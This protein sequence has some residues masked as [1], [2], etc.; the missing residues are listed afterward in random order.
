MLEYAGGG[1]RVAVEWLLDNADVAD[2]AVDIFPAVATL[3][4]DDC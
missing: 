1:V 2:A 3:R 4:C